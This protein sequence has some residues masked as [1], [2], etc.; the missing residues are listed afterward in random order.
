MQRKEDIDTAHDLRVL[1]A[2]INAQVYV[3][4]PKQFS[5]FWEIAEPLIPERI[6]A[7]TQKAIDKMRRD[8]AQRR[9]NALDNVEKQ[10]RH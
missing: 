7:E 10:L 9:W 3:Q 5:D 6:K 8:E 2:N 1:R 4:D